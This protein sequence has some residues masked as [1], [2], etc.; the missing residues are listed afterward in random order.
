MSHVHSVSFVTNISASACLLFLISLSTVQSQDNAKDFIVRDKDLATR[1]LSASYD[2]DKIIFPHK[3]RVIGVIDSLLKDKK[4]SVREQCS[5]SLAHL[6]EGLELRK[7]WAY[8][9]IDATGRGKS[10]LAHGYIGDLGHREE[11]LGIRVKGDQQLQGQY[12]LV[13][14]KF[15]ATPKRNPNFV[16]PQKL[17]LSDAGL[18]GTIYEHFGN[19]SEIF[20][21][22]HHTF[23]LCTPVGCSPQDVSAILTG[24]TGDKELK[25]ELKGVE[26]CEVDESL[27]SFA[28]RQPAHR[29][30]S[31]LVVIFMVNL[32]GVS[33]VITYFLGEE[34]SFRHFS[35]Y[36][37][38][39]KL[40]TD[41][42]DPYVK[43]M[44][45]LDT[46]KFWYHTCGLFAH[47]VGFVPLVPLVFGVMQDI[48]IDLE[49]QWMVTEYAK[50]A[51]YTTQL[52]FLISG[53]FSCYFIYPIIVKN[54]GKMSF[55]SYAIKRWLR[56]A[57]TTAGMILLM[58]TAACFMRGPLAGDFL[59]KSL[60]VC[61][62]DWW[63]TMLYINNYQTFSTICIP[64]SWS[65]SVDFHLWLL[66]YF[67][68]I[69]L[70]KKPKLG[71]AAC[72]FLIG[73]GVAIPAGMM[74]W[75]EMPSTTSGRPID[76]LFYMLHGNYFP[77]MH[78][79]T[80]N[81]MASY[82]AGVLLG[83]CFATERRPP[84]GFLSLFVLC[85][86]LWS[87]T[88]GSIFAPYVWTHIL[89]FT[90]NRVMD[91]IY[92][93]FFRITYM[94]VFAAAFMFQFYEIDFCRKYTPI[95]SVVSESWIYVPLGRLSYSVFLSQLIPMAW[96]LTVSYE[97]IPI[98]RYYM[99]F[100]FISVNFTCWLFGF[101][102][103]IV[104]EAPFISMS[105]AYLNKQNMTADSINS[106]ELDIQNKQYQS[107]EKKIN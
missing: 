90:I 68:L 72:L 77:M 106:S 105:K 99:I 94:G 37:N 34:T 23:A 92:C 58:F 15:P 67:P 21:H 73:L 87:I 18:Q 103:F 70:Y 3:E 71:V 12:C 35:V 74:L 86:C 10:G 85:T 32:V 45:F 14:L 104:F 63:K 91:A 28:I 51:I 57:P 11:C 9:F 39:V 96:Y 24:L 69:W 33:T 22:E 97:Q 38:L 75:Y 5:A 46:F 95:Y 54:D 7:F 78:I 19:H 2:F 52:I 64:T 81:N 61:K 65:Q 36:R 44:K 80:H 43:R 1:W 41:Y 60:E 20:H 17:D 93:G 4:L 56:T 89:G 62:N 53:M 40:C 101:F 84:G 98:N 76:M 8:K 13:H 88:I 27:I 30:A 26:P 29:L 47:M 42:K 16:S 25:A 83:Y 55:F 66:A 82:F 31:L 48:S 102:M 107:G 50:K 49:D 59:H 6:K 100:R 79:G